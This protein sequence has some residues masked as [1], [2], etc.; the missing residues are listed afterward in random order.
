MLVGD[1]PITCASYTKVNGISHIEGCQWFKNLAKRDKPDL[2]SIASPKGEMKSTF[3]KISLF[4]SPTSSTLCFGEPTL[5]KLSQVKLLCSPHQALYVRSSSSEKGRFSDFHASL[6][7]TPS[8]RMILDKQKIEVTKNP[9]HPV[10]KN[11]EHS[12][13]QTKI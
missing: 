12:S 1:D 5:G 13:S 6:V 8:S 9:I 2:S 10:G 4:M 7:S 11:G 3:S